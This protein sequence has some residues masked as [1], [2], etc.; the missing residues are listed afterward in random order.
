MI[1]EWVKEQ[2]KSGLYSDELEDVVCN[3]T[4]IE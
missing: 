1:K 3:Y 2:L 4:K